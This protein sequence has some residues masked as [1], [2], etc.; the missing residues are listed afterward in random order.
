MTRITGMLGA[1]LLL[2]AGETAFAQ[3]LPPLEAYGRLPEVDLCELSP[4]GNRAASRVTSNGRDLVVVFDL[5][6]MQVVTAA[7]AQEVNPRYIRFVDD[8]SVVLVAGKTVRTMAVRDSFDYSS[9]Y[10]FDVSTKS[11]P[12]L[13]RR[14]LD[15]ALLAL[16]VDA[17]QLAD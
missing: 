2:A 9:A 4:S 17:G 11:I 14:W 16:V 12:G 5:A 7:D 3:D 10:S 8:D 6:T 15:A 1:L 13:D